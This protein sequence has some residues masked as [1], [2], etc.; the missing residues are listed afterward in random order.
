[1]FSRNVIYKYFGKCLNHIMPN[2]SIKLIFMIMTFDRISN[3]N[4]SMM[5]SVKYQNGVSCEIMYPTTE[6]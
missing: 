5:E 4:I 1:M 2:L 6:S 3:Q